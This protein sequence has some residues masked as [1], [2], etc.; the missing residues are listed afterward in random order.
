ML[1]RSAV[2][3]AIKLDSPGPVLFRQNRYGFGDRV[4]GVYKFRTMRA[5]LADTNGEKQTAVNDPRITRV[6]AFLRR[7]SL[8]E[9]PQL[10]NVLRGELSLVGPRPHAISMHVKQRRNEDIVPDYALRHHVKPGITGWAQVNGY[11]GPVDTERHLQQR[12]AYDLD[13]INHWSLW[14]DIRII[15]KTLL[16]AFVHREAY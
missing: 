11:H 2:A 7:T 6:G 1:F 14:F 10:F 15:L 13:Y 16:I 4:I 3:V 8:D 12:V 5:D 9:L